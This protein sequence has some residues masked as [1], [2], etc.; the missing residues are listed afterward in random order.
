MPSETGYFLPDAHIAV[1]IVRGFGTAIMH[2]GAT[3]IF[4]ITAM[5]LVE[6]S[7]KSGIKEFLP[8]FI[9]AVL[10]HSTYNHFFL[11]PI[12]QALGIVVVLPGLLFLVF[13]QSEKAVENWL[14]VGFDADTELLE[15]ISS[16]ALSNSPV[17]Q[18]LHELKDRFRGEVVADLICYLRLHTELALRAK[19]VLM[20]RESGFK[21]EIGEETQAKFTEMRYLEKSIGKT[22]QL[23]MKPFLHLS[24]KNLWQQYVL[25]K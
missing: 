19:G 17:G 15:L 5:A 14:D 10:L 3:A 18:Y 8:G 4:A 6:R 7:E 9:V 12:F 2:G 20:M 25:G 13:Q 1:W 11:L 23:A 21:V 22:G 16:G 24:R